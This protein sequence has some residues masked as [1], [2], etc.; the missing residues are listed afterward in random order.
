M[1]PEKA[2][3]VQQKRLKGTIRD[4]CEVRCRRAATQTECGR[5]RARP[6]EKPEGHASS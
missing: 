2:E 6:S 3:S 5:D 1:K 4:E